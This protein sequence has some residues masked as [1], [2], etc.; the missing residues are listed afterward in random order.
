MYLL[1]FLKTE[2]L[3]L[4]DVVA[5]D[6]ADRSEKSRVIIEHTYTYRI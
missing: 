1:I 5:G 3:F 2:K 4:F 6:V